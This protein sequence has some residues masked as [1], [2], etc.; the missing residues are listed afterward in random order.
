MRL[1][2]GARSERF[3][4]RANRRDLAQTRRA[5]AGDAAPQQREALCPDIDP[6]GIEMGL[7]LLK[8]FFAVLGRARDEYAGGDRGQPAAVQGMLWMKVF[9]SQRLISAEKR[10]LLISGRGIE[11]RPVEIHRKPRPAGLLPSRIVSAG[12]ADARLPSHRERAESCRVGAV[13]RLRDQLVEP[14]DIGE[15]LPRP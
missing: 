7:N 10:E 13:E 1:H 4:R 11:E 3:E 2:L 15:R 8:A 9:E 12:L 5:Y 6:D 14:F